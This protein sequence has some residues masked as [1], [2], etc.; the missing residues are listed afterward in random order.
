MKLREMRKPI[1]VPIAFALAAIAGGCGDAQIERPAHAVWCP[2][3]VAAPHR[4]DARDALGL[5]EARVVAVARKAGCALVVMRRDD[6]QFAITAN[7][8]PR[9]LRVEVDDGVVTRLIGV[10]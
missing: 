6:Q 9:R 4:V 8:D 7:Y 2:E 1:W 5:K 3:R 10:G